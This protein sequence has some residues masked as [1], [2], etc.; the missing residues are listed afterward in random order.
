MLPEMEDGDGEAAMDL[1][2]AERL[3]LQFDAGASPGIGDRMLFEGHDRTAAE[4]YLRAVDEIRRCTAEDGSS[5]RLVATIQVA[6][7]RLEDELRNIL[8]TRVIA[9]EIESLA[10][11]LTLVS[12][13]SADFSADGVGESSGGEDGPD[14]DDEASEGGS[15]HYG[16]A[17]GRSSNAA[18]AFSHRLGNSIREI[19]L[20]PDDAIEDARTVAER[21]TA[22]GYSKECFQVHVS[23]RKAAVDATLSTL[24]VERISI[25]EVQRLD[26]EVLEGK[27]RRWIRAAK[28]CI[29]VVFPSERRLWDLVFDGLDSSNEDDAPFLE[30]IKGAAIRLLNFA[31]AISISRRTPEKLFK[32]L[33]LHDALS[34]LL[35]DM[36]YVF[37]RSR[38]SDPIHSQA[39]EIVDRLA[40]AARGILSEFETAVQRD[41][42][43]V[44]ARGGTIHPLTRYVMNYISLIA[45]YK[46]TLGEMIASKPSTSDHGEAELPEVEDQSPLAAHL[47]WVV[48]LL[49]ANLERKARLYADT[50][51]YHFFLMNNVHYIVHKVR[52][53]PELRQ[54]IE[55]DYQRRLTGKYQQSATSYRRSS[56]VRVIQCLTDDGLPASGSFSSAAGR[57][58]LREKFRA[59]NAAFEEVH[60]A[61]SL[62]T[63]PDQQLREELKIS[64]SELL[65][66]AYRA[67]VG[68]FGHHIQSGRHPEAYIRYSV[69]DLETALLDLF[70]GSAH[71]HH[72]RRRSYST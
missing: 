66:P 42:S 64:V 62:W 63:A 24:G 41:P 48:V 3:I 17:I 35:P 6:M 11:D 9:L 8:S 40:D 34:E 31:E 61:Q 49:Q 2:A 33:D 71:P 10:A 58:K 54:M 12:V 15:Y 29:R 65:I 14:A 37:L 30:I 36:A 23:A 27:I 47:T 1:A 70:E 28:V 16:A 57:A 67:F 44:P 21:M 69:E 25:G 19:D 5:S 45:D 26:W 52:A 7:A 46:P 32:I 20:L 59:F 50:S 38:V 72:S 13:S 55:E 68:R 56:W 53:H 51:L 4:G 39:T 22:C 18:S 43:Q 60:R